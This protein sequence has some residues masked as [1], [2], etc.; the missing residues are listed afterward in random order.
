M[1]SCAIMQPTYLPWSGY[2]A[3]MNQVDV[4]VFLDDVQFARNTWQ[5]ENRALGA[6]GPVNLVV[7]VEKQPLQERIKNI[8]I[9]YST[10]WVDSHRAQIASC[11]GELNNAA[12]IIGIVSDCFEKRPVLLA[13]LN[14]DLIV[15]MARYVGIATRSLRASDLNCGGARSEHVALICKAVG[16]DR[17]VSPEGAREYLTA[18]RFVEQFGILLS[19]QSFVPRPYDQG[20]RAEFVSHLSMLDVICRVGPT[21]AK[22]YIS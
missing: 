3:L 7:S 22:C 15:S 13:D 4:F 2:F 21:A 6:D 20:E 12:E 8:R 9:D 16:A 5:S 19:Y 10:G 11:Y 14:V 17:Y 18:D 1:T